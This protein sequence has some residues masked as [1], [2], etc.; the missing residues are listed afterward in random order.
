MTYKD[1]CDLNALH[2]AQKRVAQIGWFAGFFA[3]ASLLTH[4]AY[5]RKMAYG[6]KG[7]SFLL[8]AATVKVGISAYSSF[9]YGPL[10]GAYLRKYSGAARSDAWELRDRKREFYQI[11]DSQYMDYSEEQVDV[12][13]HSN[14]GPQPDGEAKDASYLTELDAFLDGKPN[15]LK[16][17]E[18]FLNYN[19]TFKDKS[20]PTLEA[21]KDLI[22]KK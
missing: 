14:H 8:T 12:H 15:H 7:L 21:A 17:H 20:Y 10:I 6:W 2:V 9:T 22:E 13:R 19:Y 16:D 4:D 11:D 5:V 3:A 18:K 1:R